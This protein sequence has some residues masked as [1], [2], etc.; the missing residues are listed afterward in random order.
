[1][2]PDPILPRAHPDLLSRVDYDPFKVMPGEL[3]PSPRAFTTAAHIERARARVA[4]GSRVD[5][6][7]LDMLIAACKLDL[8]LPGI[9]DPTGPPDWGGGSVAPPLN[10]AFRNAMAWRLTDNPR[11]RERALEAMRLAA[12]ACAHAKKWTGHEHHEAGNAGC[13][14]DLL[15][16]GR[17]TPQ[18]DTAFQEMLRTLVHALDQG[19]HSHCNNHNAMQMVGRLAIGAALGDRQV[20]HDTLY[21]CQREGKW[22][23]GLIHLMR[24][25]FLADG[26]QWEG[27]TGYHMLVLMMV[28]ECFTTL[29][30]MGVD[31]WRREWPSTLKDEGFDEHRGWGPRGNKTLTAAFDTL[32]YQAFTNG[33]YCLLHDQVLGNLR[34]TWVWWRLFNKAYE[35][36]GEPRYAWALKH[37]NGGKPATADG[38]IP[39]WFNSGH[40]DVEF[41]RFEAR[42]FPD[43]KA[44]YDIDRDFALTGRHV[45]GCS[46]FPAHG[47][48]VL[49]SSANDDKAL[50]AYLYWGPHSAG[51]RSPAALHLD[52]HA[53]GRRATNAPH[54]YKRGYDEPLHLTWFRSTIAHNTVAVDQQSMFPY[55]FETD[56][57]WEYE[58]WRDSVSDS[59]LES[60]QPE[61]AFKAVRASNDNVYRG[62]KLDR[63]VVL[64]AGYV[65]DVYR[66]MA[67][68][69]R[70][71]D[72]AMHCH[73]DFTV[74]PNAKPIDLGQ[75]RGYRHFT[76][77]RVLPTGGGWAQVPYTFN[78]GPALASLWL[79]GA[80]GAKLIVARDPVPD[81]RN[82]IGNEFKPEPRTSLIVRSNT[83]SALFVSVWSFGAAAAKGVKAHGTAGGDVTVEVN[84]DN[85]TSRWLLPMR[86]DV[87]L[88]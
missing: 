23:Y 68:R 72:W 10:T 85:R 78:A 76:D 73:G 53:L 74:D 13:A 49:R 59:V 82:H 52:I 45:A 41:V 71:L 32:I 64:T 14:Y 19:G 63:T 33:D 24:H 81:E 62:V 26:M 12:H 6:H 58:I 8:P 36:F 21:G 60:F 39:V 43:A 47:S 5:R 27:V 15:A 88:G 66:V 34:G 77:A 4:A 22:R 75:N 44:P 86:G 54:V 69:A 1:M 37:I 38:P 17:L 20:I 84:H 7:C 70:L 48:T 79:D 3:P 57:L 35:V 80:P 61:A 87:S 29:E 28:C 50:G 40:S 46:N 31:L 30:N 18:D 67:D 11:H 2:Y 9:K 55:D 25:D 42:E 83:A 16:D 51:H 65:L 56:S